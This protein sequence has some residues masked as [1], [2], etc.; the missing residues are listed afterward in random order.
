MDNNYITTKD[1][2]GEEALTGAARREAME[3]NLKDE[4]YIEDLKAELREEILE[5]LEE[6]KERK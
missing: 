6:Q 2:S 5:E 4:Q 3:E 1:L